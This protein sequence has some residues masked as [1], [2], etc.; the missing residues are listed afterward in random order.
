MYPESPRTLAIPILGKIA[1]GD[2]ITAEENIKGYTYESPENLPKGNL[3]C[4]EATGDSMYPTVP[5]GSLVTI[6]EQATVESGEIAAVLINGNEEA[7]LK[8]IKKHGETVFLIS[9]NTNYDPIL[10]T[11]ENPAKII[12][13]AVRVIKNL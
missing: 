9:D 5:N 11:E 1:C 3:F 7:V 4:L 12:G 13:K 8:R 6:R 10:V 2:P